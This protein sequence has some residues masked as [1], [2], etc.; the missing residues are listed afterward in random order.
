MIVSEYFK[1]GGK[2]TMNESV[3]VVIETVTTE[4]IK[5]QKEFNEMSERNKKFIEDTR[6]RMKKKREMFE[7]RRVNKNA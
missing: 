5:N 1:L 4:I 7:K 3:K 2:V 6:E